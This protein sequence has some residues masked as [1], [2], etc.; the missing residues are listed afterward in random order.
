MREPAAGCRHGQSVGKL[1]F[2]GGGGGAGAM[3]D[4]CKDAKALLF[5]GEELNHRTFR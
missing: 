2:I 3:D 1:S 4:D 5:A